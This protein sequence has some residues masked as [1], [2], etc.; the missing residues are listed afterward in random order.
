M[1]VGGTNSRQTRYRGGWQRR[2]NL[3]PRQVRSLFYCSYTEN[4]F[5]TVYEPTV[6]DNFA[7]TI[8]IDGKVVNLGLW[9]TFTNLGTQQDRNNIIDLD[10]LHILIVM[11]S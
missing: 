7:T 9:Y 8:K 5:P 10:L 3:H 6:F 2:K 11:S 1:N 4:K